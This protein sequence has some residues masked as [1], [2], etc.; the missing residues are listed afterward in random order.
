MNKIVSL[1]GLVVLSFAALSGSVYVCAMTVPDNECP[2]A[3]VPHN[4]G[5]CEIIYPWSVH[6][7]R[8]DVGITTTNVGQ[9]RTVVGGSVTISNC[10]GCP[11]NI[12]GAASRTGYPNVT[13]T[14]VVTA[15]VDSVLHDAWMIKS[16]LE[17]SIGHVNQRSFQGPLTCTNSALPGCK[18]QSITAELSVTENIAKKIVHQYMW[19]A[20]VSHVGAIVVLCPKCGKTAWDYPY[21]YLSSI[22]SRTSTV[23]GS[24][25]GN[26]NCN[27]GSLSNCP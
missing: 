16:N 13:Y 23:V 26:P 6:C 7:E 10:V 14:E 20:S 21:P 4:L 22:G 2:S 3:F 8:T 24:S 9:Q 15:T 27:F 17:S 25:Y 5:T 19:C 12:P 18:M 1:V 11:E